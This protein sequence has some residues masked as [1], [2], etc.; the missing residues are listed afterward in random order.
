M[1]A[2]LPITPFTR[3]LQGSVRIPGSKSITNRALL[4]AAL[5]TKGV[6]LEEALFSEDTEVMV[7][8]LRNL[9]FNVHRDPGA[10]TVYIEGQGGIIPNKK[11]SLYFA[12]AGTAAR[13]IT[14]LCALHPCGTY[15]LDGSHAMRKRPMRGLLDAL[16]A[17]GAQVEFSGEEGFLPLTLKT[18]GLRGGPL[19]LDARASSQILSALLMVAP[20]SQ[21][22][23]DITLTGKTVSEPFVEMTRSMMEQ[24]GYQGVAITANTHY[25]TQ[26]QS[27]YIPPDRYTIEPDASAASYFMA[28]PLVTGGSLAIENLSTITLQGDIAFAEVLEALGF[29]IERT[30]AS[31]TFTAPNA[32]ADV[33]QKFNFNSISDT[34]LTLAALAPLFPQSL[35]IDGLAHTRHQETDRICAMQTELQR[36]NQEVSCTEDSI[37]IHP[38]PL[39]AATIQTYHDHRVA[40]SFAILGSLD[41]NQN[42]TPWISISDPGCCAKTFP[43]F[44]ETLASIHERAHE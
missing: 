43:D 12:N 24:F 8:C 18:Q 38:Q 41:F 21:A 26:T 14:A 39:K 44:F 2:T 37:T 25:H 6:L 3:P 30:H 23:L 40:M 11:A 36:L 13:F 19:T 1:S 29:T 20:F 5:S 42:G 9:G 15:A 16:I 35:T 17:Q 4:L 31:W 28:L 34:F 10:C 27:A 22:P 33:P 7:D 32:L